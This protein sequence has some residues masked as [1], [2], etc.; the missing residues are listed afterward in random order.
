MQFHICSLPCYYKEYKQLFSPRL[1]GTSKV[2]VAVCSP[3]QGCT[4][5]EWLSLTIPPP[6]PRPMFYLYLFH[7]SW[8][9]YWW[10]WDLWPQT[11]LLQGWAGD[12]AGT[13]EAELLCK[14]SNLT[15]SMNFK[16]SFKGMFLNSFISSMSGMFLLL[17]FQKNYHIMRLHFV[18]E[19]FAVLWGL[20]DDFWA[21]GAASLDE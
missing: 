6:P 14:C 9:A 4:G 2:A 20:T 13:L 17:D 7:S 5:K 18:F 12:L 8:H 15:E 3:L 19:C 1:C 10:L 21:F 11:K 16:R